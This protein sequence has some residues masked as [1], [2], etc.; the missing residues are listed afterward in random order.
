MTVL[1]LMSVHLYSTLD[2]VEH[3]GIDPVLLLG[4]FV[5]AFDQTNDR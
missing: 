3:V 2:P 1:P 4:I 5:L